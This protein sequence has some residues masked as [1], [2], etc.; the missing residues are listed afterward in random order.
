MNFNY[1]WRNNLIAFYSIADAFQT[2]CSLPIFQIDLTGI[3]LG[4]LF[5]ETDD[6]PMM[7]AVKKLFKDPIYSEHMKKLLYSLDNRGAF[8]E[9]I[10]VAA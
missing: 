5:N 8:D 6:N 10:T 4:E 3:E 9:R 1:F 2:L 7:K